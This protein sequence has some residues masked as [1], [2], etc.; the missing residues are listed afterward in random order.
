[1]TTQHS[2]TT[3]L[4]PPAN[5]AR[6][7]TVELLVGSYLALSVLT[8]AMVVVL[9]Q[10][11]PHLVNPQAWVRSIIVAATSLLTFRFATRA[12]RGKPRAL[13]RLR[14]VVSIL[15]IAII[16][17]L[18]FLPLPLW[19]VIEQAVCGLLLLATTIIIFG[20]GVAATG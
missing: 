13:L 10:L 19:M 3:P 1:M 6:L 2:S 14:I 15:L 4:R 5:K 7:R 17:V 12:A 9:S 18:F 8:V 16:A 20:K 11:A